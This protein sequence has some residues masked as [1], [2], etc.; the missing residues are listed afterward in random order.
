LYKEGVN[1]S[2]KAI[3]STQLNMPDKT[4]KR[5]NETISRKKKTL[6]KN[7]HKFGKLLGIDIAFTIYQNGQYTTYQSI[8]QAD[9]PPPKK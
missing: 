1:S 2:A 5:Q 6:I 8:D 3:A 9:F 4:R 7:I